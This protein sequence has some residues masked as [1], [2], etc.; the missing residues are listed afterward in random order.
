MLNLL[1]FLANFKEITDI[2]Q[3]Y[4]LLFRN[5]FA[6]LTKSNTFWRYFFLLVFVL[7]IHLFLWYCR[8]LRQFWIILELI[9]LTQW[10]N[11]RITWILLIIKRRVD[12]LAAA[13]INY[14]RFGHNCIGLRGRILLET[15]DFQLIFP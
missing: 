14:D 10:L 11:H 3:N 5:N 12:I 15:I 7:N 13:K 6:W 4:L 1:L 8:L 2:V 9:C